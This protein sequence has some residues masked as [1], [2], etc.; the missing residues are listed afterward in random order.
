VMA[1]ESSDLQ[2][3]MIL[4]EMTSS[5]EVFN[6]SAWISRSTSNTFARLNSDRTDNKQ[7]TWQVEVE[8]F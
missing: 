7:Y 6:G 4:V 2:Y 3:L 5:G 8:I 1:M